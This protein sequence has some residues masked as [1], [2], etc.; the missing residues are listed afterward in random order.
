MA[1]TQV[2]FLIWVKVQAEAAVAYP[3][4]AG[5]AALAVAEA[6]AEAP[7]ETVGMELLL[8]VAEVVVA[9][10]LMVETVPTRVAVAHTSAV[11]QVAAKI[12]AMVP[13]APAAVA[14]EEERSAAA[15]YSFS[16]EAMEPM[17]PTAAVAVAV[18]L[19]HPTT[20]VVSMRAE[21]VV[22]AD[23]AVV[24]EA[25]GRSGL[26]SPAVMEEMADLAAAQASA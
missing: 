12:M 21:V 16:M 8:A 3:A 14:A 22:M 9:P 13:L 5:E 10:S 6:V 7:E 1:A 4:T 15:S 2:A 24:V 11:A 25:Q 23:L 20:A 19:A 17:E 18:V 26:C